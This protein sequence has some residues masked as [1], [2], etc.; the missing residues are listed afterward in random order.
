MLWILVVAGGSGLPEDAAAERGVELAV[1]VGG[2]GDEQL[3]DEQAEGESFGCTHGAHPL[4]GREHA[5]PLH[6]LC[7]QGS[8]NFFSTL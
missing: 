5:V 2:A 8:F 1:Q 7:Q 3:G 4:R 6:L